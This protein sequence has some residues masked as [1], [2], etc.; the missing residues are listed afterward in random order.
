MNTENRVYYISDKIVIRDDPMLNCPV[1][2]YDPKA[3][4]E[5]I[6]IALKHCK[7]K[8]QTIRQRIQCLYT[9]RRLTDDEERETHNGSDNQS[10]RG[11]VDSVQRNVESTNGGH[12]KE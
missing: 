9:L 4:P 10:H 8:I 6:N 3:T 5:D 1:L 2:E 12:G 11:A 7:M